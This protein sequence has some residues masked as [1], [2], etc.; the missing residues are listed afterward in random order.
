M[1][2]KKQYDELHDPTPATHG[3]LNIW[4]GQ[5]ST[6]AEETREEVREVKQQL[7]RMETKID[8]LF[9][10]IDKRIDHYVENRAPNLLGVKHDEVR[11]I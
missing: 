11:E 6:Q 7:N 5:L 1:A 4:G 2:K 9:D 3:D 8:K 10:H